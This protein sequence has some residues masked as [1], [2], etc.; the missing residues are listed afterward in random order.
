VS[1]STH[2]CVFCDHE[3]TGRRRK[4]CFDCLP[5]HDE[6]PAEYM[7]KYNLLYRACG[8]NRQFPDPPTCS[9]KH[10]LAKL[11]KPPK[12]L[13]KCEGCDEMVR[14]PRQYCSDVCRARLKRH[15]IRRERDSLAQPIPPAP[16]ARV[17]AWAPKPQSG[18]RGVIVACAICGTH[19]QRT[20]GALHGCSPDCRR[21]L[22]RE[23]DRRKRM[24]RRTAL[25][26]DTYTVAELIR[27]DGLKCH[28]CAK[29]MDPK[30][31]GRHPRGITIDHLVPLS[32]G[33]A[34]CKTN[35]ALA[36]LEC[37]VRRGADGPAQLRLV[38]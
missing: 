21:Q 34:D 38:G 18:P 8:L 27:R 23:R 3:F 10:L 5:D 6:N 28:I 26:G 13:V 11:P 14:P 19:F 36:H 1:N 24:R 20:T 4:F 7:R 37:N 16:K 30:L 22:E 17:V 31:N 33:G 15:A 9:I 32:A 2:C 29:P 12:P 35:V 25:S